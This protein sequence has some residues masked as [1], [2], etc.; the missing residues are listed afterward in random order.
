MNAGDTGDFISKRNAGDTGDFISKRNASAICRVFVA[1]AWQTQHAFCEGR[2][3]DACAIARI[4]GQLQYQ[5]FDS[6][7]IGELEVQ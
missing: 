7:C 4:I 3:E 5:I 2:P 1:L 6:E